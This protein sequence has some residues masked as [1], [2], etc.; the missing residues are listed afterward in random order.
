MLIYIS[1]TKERFMF[2]LKFSNNIFFVFSK[3]KTS[4]MK[5]NYVWLTSPP[6]LKRSTH[7][8]PDLYSENHLHS[9]NSFCYRGNKFITNECFYCRNE[10]NHQ[11]D[12]KTSVTEDD[13][14]RN[15]K[16]FMFY[17]YFLTYFYL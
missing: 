12:R 5:T 1:D 3:E 11:S 8:F 15:T 10:L 16:Y 2:H 17:F 13:K 14:L 9:V 6:P 4:V 7:G